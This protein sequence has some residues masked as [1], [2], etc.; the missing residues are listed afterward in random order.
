VGCRERAPKDALLRLAVVDG[1]IAPDASGSAP[2]RGAYVHRDAAC[3]ERALGRGTLVR[4]FRRAGV[5]VEVG[6]LRD[7]IEGVVGQ[8]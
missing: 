7:V 8:G 1:A 6:R 5:H 2:G 3:V 4:A